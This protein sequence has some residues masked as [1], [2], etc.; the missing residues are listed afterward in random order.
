M[1]RFYEL[2]RGDGL[3]PADALRQAQRWLRDTSTASYAGRSHRYEHP[4]HWAAFTYV[5]A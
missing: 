1:T 3:E 4:V 2:W 5:G